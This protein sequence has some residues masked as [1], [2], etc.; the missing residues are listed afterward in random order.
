[1]RRR[2]KECFFVVTAFGY[3]LL[4]CGPSLWAL[5]LA[6]RDPVM[7]C[8]AMVCTCRMHPG[9][10]GAACCCVAN[11]ALLRKHPGLA[12]DPGFW[13]ALGL[14]PP[15]PAGTCQLHADGCA[16]LES[17]HGMAPVAQQP[18]LLPDGMRLVPAVGPAAAFPVPSRGRSKDPD[19]PRPGPD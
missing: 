5:D 8:M 2:L 6:P 14:D 3:G 16:P 10:K 4:G 13:K 11:Q 12:R 15:R 19:A 18:H 1:M 7:A 17:G 9:K